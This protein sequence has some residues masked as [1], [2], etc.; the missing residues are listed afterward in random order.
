MLAGMLVI[1]FGSRSLFSQLCQSHLQPALSPAPMR[2]VGELAGPP[3]GRPRST[4]VPL[5]SIFLCLGHIYL[6]V[7]I[8]LLFLDLNA[9]Q[10]CWAA[11]S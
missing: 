11:I 7:S 1:T 2:P 10:I 4:R 6:P 3:G 9:Y 8:S 5:G